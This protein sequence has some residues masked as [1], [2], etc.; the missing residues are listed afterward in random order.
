[1][2][3]V[4]AMLSGK[5]GTGKTTVCAGLAVALAALENTVLCIDLDMGLRN[6]D[7]ALG[8][9]GEP[10]L[11]FCDVMSGEA[12]LDDATDHPRIPGLKLLTAP[13]GAISAPLD[14]KQFMRMI[15]EAREAFDYVLLDAPAGVGEP[16]HLAAEA[17]SMQLLV[18]G[19]D[20]ATMRDGSRAGELLE[21]MGKTDVR[22]IVNRVNPKVYSAMG[23]TVDDVMDNVGY[24]LMGLVPEDVNVL[25]AATEEVAVR[26][27]TRKGAAAAFGRIA[28]RIIGKRVPLGIVK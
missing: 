2:G 3:M 25:L 24:G 14:K 7:I 27:Y 9:P 26:E 12:V 6:L 19:P 1:M 28:K 5:G 18:V 4:I 16:F 10:V 8:M 20:P 13:M 22:L 23:M 17:S 21:L 15:H 11:T